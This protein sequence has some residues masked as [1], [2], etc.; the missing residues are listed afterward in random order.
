MTLPEFTA[1][2]SLKDTSHHYPMA[3]SVNQADGAIM[4][5]KAFPI[6]DC[7]FWCMFNA[8]RRCLA[9]CPA[10]SIDCI[11]M[12]LIRARAQCATLCH[13]TW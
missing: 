2:A 6:S 8:K 1:E 7:Y 9:L 11:P 3:W 4:P 5:A 10:H 13:G 12:C